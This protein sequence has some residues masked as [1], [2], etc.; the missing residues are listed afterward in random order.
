MIIIY[1]C[2]HCNYLDSDKDIAESHCIDD[3]GT[4]W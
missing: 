2:P 4:F 1:E 3:Q